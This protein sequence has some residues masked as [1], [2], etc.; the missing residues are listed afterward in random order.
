MLI[1]PKTLKWKNSNSRTGSTISRPLLALVNQVL[2][3]EIHILLVYVLS[4]AHVALQELS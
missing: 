2:L 1:V 3:A 4:M